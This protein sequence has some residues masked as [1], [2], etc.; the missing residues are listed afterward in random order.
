MSSQVETHK[1]RQ[2]KALYFCGSVFSFTNFSYYGMNITLLLFMTTAIAGG[3]LGISHAEAMALSGTL[4]A[5][6]YLSPVAGG[7][8]SDRFLGPKICIVAG[9]II[10]GLG[11]FAAYIA[12]DITM[13]YLMIALCVIGSGLY[14]STS[15]T[16]VG[17]LY[18][19]DDP[20]KDGAFSMNYTFT[21]IGVFFGPFI[22]GLVTTQ[23][24]ATK[25]GSEIISYGYREVFL[26]V[27]IVIWVGALFFAL[28]QKKFL[29]NIK[30]KTVQPKTL[31]DKKALAAI[32][33]TRTDKRRM[34]VI[35][36]LALVTVVFWVAYM[37]AWSSIVLYSQDFVNLN[38]GSFEIPL[39]WA[40]SFNGL[41]CVI[42][43]PITSMTWIKLSKTKRGDLTISQKMSLGFIFLAVAFLFMI[44]AVLQTGT[45]VGEGP[46]ASILLVIAFFTFQSIGEM[47]FAPVGYGMVSKLAPAK[48]AALFMGV[49]FASM[50]IANQLSGYAGYAIE[51]MGIL[52]VFTIIPIT[53]VVISILLLFF[54]KNIEEMSK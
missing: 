51:K 25:E 29:G 47:C 4:A 13:I 20:R 32:P 23:W 19:N 17:T 1:L 46:K 31:E 27:A 30:T 37:Q 26:T 45:V 8:I 38:L 5:L 44:V 28:F 24:F 7:W 12:Q 3:G 42:L 54:S 2:P 6:S 22:A 34:V 18:D 50:A 39:A 49:W 10:M 52:Q 43:G 9:M 35:V 48:F 15:Q 11:Y 16:L 36:I 21:N 41:L 33:L 14:K 40:S 53:L